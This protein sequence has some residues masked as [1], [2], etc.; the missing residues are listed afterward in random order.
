M[1]RRRTF[2]PIEAARSARA[3]F[4]RQGFEASSVSDLE[5]ATG[6]N[7]SS[8]YHEFGSKR[9][10]F[11]AAAD[12]YLDEVARPRLRVLTH[13]P[14]PPDAVGMYLRSLRDALLVNASAASD[15]GCLIVNTAGSLIGKDEAVRDR[16]VAYRT[17][18]ATAIE[19]G[20]THQPGFD[21]SRVKPT[22]TAITSLVVAAM[23]LTRVDPTAAAQTLD[24]AVALANG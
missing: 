21:S 9:G 7:R 6:L 10:L 3:V 8:L 12:N 19:N 24:I 23:T 17:E 5:D 18:I 11:D 1:G 22:A 16:I 2:D 20:L 4:W 14:I 15:H 13:K